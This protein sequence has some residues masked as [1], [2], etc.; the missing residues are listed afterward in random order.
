LQ[1]VAREKDG[2]VENLSE[3]VVPVLRRDLELAISGNIYGDM[4]KVTAL[5]GKRLGLESLAI[6]LL[7]QSLE[8]VPPVLCPAQE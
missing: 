2:K 4:E 6:S 5:G 3:R 1:G 8:D 7:F